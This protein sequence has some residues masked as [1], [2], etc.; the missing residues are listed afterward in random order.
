MRLETKRGGALLAF[1][2]FLLA[3]VSAAGCGGGSADA[4]G[5]VPPCGGD[6]VGT[7]T[8]TSTCT[9]RPVLPVKLCDAATVAHSSFDVSGKATFG[10][11]QTFDI[12]L[13]ESGSIEVSVPASCLGPGDRTQACIQITPTVPTGVAARCVE[14]GDGC[15]CT[16]LLA[17]HDVAETGT[18]AT[19]GTGLTAV[20]AGGLIDGAS[21]CVAGGRLHLVSLDSSAAGSGAPAV[22]ADLVGAK[23]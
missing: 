19:T 1:P 9:T 7:W 15:L 14:S 11:D 23:R 12:S 5:Q 16:F 3:G 20:P 13:T 4:C 10:A 21:Y 8:L 17:A 6:I 18:Y 22:I 2:V